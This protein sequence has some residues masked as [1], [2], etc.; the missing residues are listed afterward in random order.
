[1]RSSV[2]ELYGEFWADR[3]FDEFAAVVNE[4]LG[5]RGPETLYDHFSQLDVRAGELVLDAGGRDGRYSVEI[6]KRFGC[7]VL[8]IDPVPGHLEQAADR[9]RSER[10]DGRISTDYAEIEQIPS[11]A[12]SIDHIWCRDVLNHVHLP[13]GM[14]E[15]FRVLRPGGG[16]LVYQTFATELLEPQEARRLYNALAIIGENMNAA[17]FEGHARRAGFVIQSIDRIDSEWRELWAESGDRQLIDELLWI[18][19]IRRSRDSLVH[20]YGHA[21]VEAQLAGASW[22]VYQ[23]L[24]KLCPTV[25]LLRKPLV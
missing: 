12:G 10:L 14:S 8:M 15:C 23:M 25:Y 5:P 2:Q 7:R 4:S 17:N 16:M 1:M 21:K 11:P 20:R 6:A 3:A 19:R 9:I 22:G 24:G 18:A 13:Q